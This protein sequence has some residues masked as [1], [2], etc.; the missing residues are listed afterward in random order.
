MLKR[1]ASQRERFVLES[2]TNPIAGPDG[3]INGRK[4]NGEQDWTSI[5][6]Q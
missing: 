1:A 3:Q 4:L 2:G 6:R 5:L